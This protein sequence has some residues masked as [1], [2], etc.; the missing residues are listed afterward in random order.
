MGVLFFGWASRLGEGRRRY[1]WLSGRGNEGVVAT[2]A[3]LRAGGR[4]S[5]NVV[6]A[7]VLERVAYMLRK[8]RHKARLP[9]RFCLTP[10]TNAT[11]SA[12]AH[13]HKNAPRMLYNEAGGPGRARRLKFSFACIRGAPGS[14][15]CEK[16]PVVENR[17][18]TSSSV[19]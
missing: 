5:P 15:Y 3:E 9:C 7:R 2:Q 6:D 12:I 13:K 17:N 8:K 18:E 10:Q 11:P 19:E 16:N 14:P 1:S 4:N